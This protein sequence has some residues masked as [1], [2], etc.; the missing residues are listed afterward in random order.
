ML[1]FETIEASCVLVIYIYLMHYGMV[2]N[3]NRNTLVLDQFTDTI[4]SQLTK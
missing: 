3:C 2:M 4:S 1:E